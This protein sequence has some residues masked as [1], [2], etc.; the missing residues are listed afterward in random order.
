MQNTAN[1]ETSAETIFHC[2]QEGQVLTSAYASGRIQ[3]G[4]LIALVDD[5]GVNDMRNH[6]VNGKGELMTGTCRSV[7]ELLPGGRICLH[8]TWQWTAAMGPVEAPSCR[9]SSV[10]W[11]GLSVRDGDAG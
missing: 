7:P 11:N 5:T 9:R 6:Q 3:T 2:Q 10:R 1:G 4:H 8:E